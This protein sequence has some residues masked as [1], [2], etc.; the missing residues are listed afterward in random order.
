MAR[1]H[2]RISRH[3]TPFFSGTGAPRLRRTSK[4]VLSAFVSASFVVIAH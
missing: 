2:Y 3:E 1:S 4:R